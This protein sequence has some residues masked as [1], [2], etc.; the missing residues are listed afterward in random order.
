[1]QKTIDFSNT[2][3]AFRAKDDAQLRK[4]RLLF[5]LMGNPLLA[6]FGPGMLSWAVK[7]G[8]PIEGAVRS[9]LFEIFCGGTSIEDTVHTSQNLHKYGVKTILDY[10]VEG[11]KTEAGFDACCNE[12]VRT[13]VHGGNTHEVEFTA[14]KLTGMASLSLLEK[15]FVPQW[16]APQSPALTADE[17]QELARVRA[18]VLRICQAA[19]DN[20][21]PVFIDAEESWI[22]DTIDVLAEEMMAKF[23]QERPLVYTTVQLYRHDRLEYLRGL[24]ARSRAQGYILGVKLVRGAYHEKEST[25]AIELGYPDPIQPN[26]AATD[27]DYDAALRLCI[28][29]IDHVAICA[30]T[31]NEASCLLLTQLM[32][33]KGIAHDHPHVV[34]A[35]LLGMSDNLSFNLAASGYN[36]AKYLPYGPV[37]SVVPYLMRR[38]QENTSVAGQTGR[39]LHFLNIEAKRRAKARG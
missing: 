5:S 33:E 11:E 39:E 9:T 35:Q 10:S 6:K 30:G 12:I 7:S 25:R 32:A 31:H 34:F 15:A 4:A 22:Q 8:L 37:K 20:Q 28:D 24:I 18:R 21:T 36:A 19:A 38:A 23:N 27:R 17:Q 2:E 16:I 13:L 29:N 3:L 26:K 14:C 1:M